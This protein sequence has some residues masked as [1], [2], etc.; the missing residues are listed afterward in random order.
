ML[1]GIGPKLLMVAVVGLT[2][3]LIGVGIYTVYL[4]TQKEDQSLNI[5]AIGDITLT[6]EKY[7]GQRITVEGYYYQGDQPDGY[8][9]I[10]SDL[11]QYPIL[12][13]SL[14]NV[15]FLNMNF[16]GLNITFDEGILYYFTGTFQSSQDELTH[17]IS[18]S[19]ILKAIEQP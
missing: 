3:A 9:Y 1:G 15:D 17:E 11:V 19:L 4:Y 16:S 6:P 7:V 10:T 13:G 18:Y 5:I 12:Q 8:G 14:E 2:I